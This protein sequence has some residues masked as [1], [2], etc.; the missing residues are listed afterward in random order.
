M[1]V[2]RSPLLEAEE[3]ILVFQ[4]QIVG[5]RYDLFVGL[6]KAGFKIWDVD[7]GTYVV[8][9]CYGEDGDCISKTWEM[10]YKEFLP[11]TGFEASEQTDYEIYFDE[12]NGKPG[13]MCE[14]WIPVKKK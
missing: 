13:L 12:P 7:P 8:F 3:R 10:F 5:Y 11:Q 6:G 1:T 14:L 2:K 4:N 9:E